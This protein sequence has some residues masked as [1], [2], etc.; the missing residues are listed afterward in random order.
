MLLYSILISLS[1]FSD[2]NLAESFVKLRHRNPYLNN[3]IF[4]ACLNPF[5]FL[6]D[7]S[8]SEVINV[9]QSMFYIIDY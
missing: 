5:D 4:S 8:T 6:E 7:E 3:V 9:Q 2:H 1:N